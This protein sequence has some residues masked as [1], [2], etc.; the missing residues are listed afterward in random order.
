MSKDRPGES[1][2]EKMGREAAEEMSAHAEALGRSLRTIKH[3]HLFEEG[4][5]AAVRAATIRKKGKP[6]LAVVPEEPKDAT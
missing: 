5:L 2:A 3:A 1:A 4:G 6:Q